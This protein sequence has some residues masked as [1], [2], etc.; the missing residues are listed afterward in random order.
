M[1]SF[2]YGARLYKR[3]RSAFKFTFVFTTSFLGVVGVVGFVF[4]PQIIALFRD[5][6]DVVRIGAL[7]LRAQSVSL[8]FLP[9]TVLGNMLFQCVGKSGRATFL[10][11]TRS[12]LFFIP[13]ILILSAVIR[14]LGVQ[15]SQAISDFLSYILAFPLAF[16]FLKNLPADGEDAA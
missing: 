15:L 1:C 11:S 2:N 3:V 9:M 13:T 12:G 16:K 10:A 7:A 8:L 14:L 6:P 4:A 5:D